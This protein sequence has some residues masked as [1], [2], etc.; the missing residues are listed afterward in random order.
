MNRQLK[1]IQ[2]RPPHRRVSDTIVSTNDSHTC[3]RD[4]LKKKKHFLSD[5]SC[6]AEMTDEWFDGYY[7]IYS[8][9]VCSHLPWQ[10]TRRTFIR[11]QSATVA[12]FIV[13]VYARMR[14]DKLSLV[15]RLRRPC[16][17][18]LRSPRILCL[19]IKPYRSS[20][21]Y[22]SVC[23]RPLSRLDTQYAMPN[24]M[25]KAEKLLHEIKGELCVRRLR[26]STQ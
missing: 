21:S 3:R 25:K 4:F 23:V 24:E 7:T 5:N 8:R 16:L 18:N 20:I 12:K 17:L 2:I 6:S 9:H 19:C 15:N 13:F 1:P 26:E 14:L 22:V 11:C 10:R